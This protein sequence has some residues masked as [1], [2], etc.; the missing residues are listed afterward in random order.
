MKRKRFDPEPVLEGLKDFQRRTVERV[1]DR[2]YR[3]DTP[4]RRFLV[5][6]EVG[7]GKTMVARV[8]LPPRG[9]VRQRVPRD[10][11]VRR[12]QRIVRECF[13]FGSATLVDRR[14]ALFHPA[15]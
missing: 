1:F 11:A 15:S 9:P 2:L 7:L 8:G 3:D 4:S 14:A 5:A 13:S 6:D 10:Q 12:P